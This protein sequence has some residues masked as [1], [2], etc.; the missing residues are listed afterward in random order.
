MGVRIVERHAAVS[1]PTAKPHVG[2]D[3]LPGVKELLWVG[4]EVFKDIQQLLRAASEAFRAMVNALPAAQLVGL[5]E[6][7]VG[8]KPL[9]VYE[10]AP[11]DGVSRRTLEQAPPVRTC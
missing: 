7:D 3:V 10:L 9:G 4:T 6:L 8:R 5:L 11:I 2:D 1:R